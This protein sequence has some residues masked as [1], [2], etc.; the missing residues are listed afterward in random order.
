MS[1]TF[2]KTTAI[3][4]IIAVLF[5]AYALGLLDPVIDWIAANLT[6]EGQ[7]SSMIEEILR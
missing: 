3:I 4:I 1:R 5:S 7:T 2:S 6:L